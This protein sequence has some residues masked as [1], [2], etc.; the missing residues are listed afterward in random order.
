[1]KKTLLNLSLAILFSLGVFLPCFADI[2]LDLY[3]AAV[4]G[5]YETVKTL[6]REGAD[7]NTRGLDRTPLMVSAGNKN[8]IEIVKFLIKQGADVNAKDKYDGETALHNACSVRKEYN[9]GIKTSDTI[10]REN[11][12]H[13]FVELLIKSGANVNITNKKG[14]TALKKAHETSK[15]R[16]K[17]VKML[18]LAGAKK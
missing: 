6:V 5:K 16:N 11:V 14:E 13:E 7:V 12:A 3:N 1:M 10:K 9:N 2:D 4:F 18:K 17:I 8:N 15:N